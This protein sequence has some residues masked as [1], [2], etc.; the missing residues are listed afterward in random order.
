[1]PVLALIASPVSAQ[2]VINEIIQNPAAVGDS[3]GEWF[4]LFNPTG[5]A[6]DIEG[7][8]IS[9]NDID[10]HLINNGGPLLVPAGGYLVLGN[11]TDSGTNGGV[12]VAYSYGSNWFLANG[13]DEVVL[14]DGFMA[15]IDRVEYDG[16]PNFPDPTGASM[17]LESPASD[18]NVGSNWCTSTSSYGAGD[19]GTPGAANDA[20]VVP[21]TPPTVNSTSPANN[22]ID[23]AEGS[24]VV[25]TFSEEVTAPDGAF[26]IDC[27]I[28]SGHAFTASASP[29]T[30]FTLN[31][32]VDFDPVEKCTVT[33]D[34]DQVADTDGSPQNMTADFL[35]TF[36]TP[37]FVIDLEPMV[38]NEI[39]QN[40]SAVSDGNGEWF[41]LYNPGTET[42]DLDGWTVKDNGSNIFVVSGTLE[43]TAGA[44]VVFGT[45]GTFA[46]NGGVNVD[47]DYP[48]FSLGNGDDELILIDDND[49][50]VDRVE[51]DGGPTFPDPNGASMA[52]AGPAVDNNIGANWCTA[53]TPYGDGDLGTP[54]AANDCPLPLLVINE[55]IQN[56]GAV[57]DSNGEWFELYNPTGSAIDIEGWT[58]KDDGSN[59]QI[60]SNGGP[61]L[62]PAGG[63]LVLGNNSDSITNGGVTVDYQYSSFTLSNGGDEVVLIDTFANE[64]DRVNYD[65]GPAFPDPNGASM[66]LSIPGF[67]NNVGANW[68]TASTPFGDGDL[69]TPGAVNDCPALEI[70]E[71]QGS[72]AFSPFENLAVITRDNVVTGVTD[73]GFFIQTPANRD[74]NDSDTSNGIF[75]FTS[76]P[77]GVDEGDLVDIVGTVVEFFSFTQFDDDGL[78]IMIT[79]TGSLL[80]APILLDAVNPDPGPFDP[81]DMERFEGMLVKLENGI[82][83]GPTDGFGDTPVTVG[84]ARTFRE[85]GIEFPSMYIGIPEWDGNQEVIEVDPDGIAGMPDANIFAT[86]TVSA[87]GP[88]GFSF[89][90]YQI[91]ARTFG[92]GADPVVEI[93]VRERG[94][95]E[96][97]VGSFNIFRL[98]GGFKKL[99]AYVIDVLRSPDILAI[100]EVADISELEAL[101]DQIEFDD[102]TV[103]YT[104]SLIDG[105]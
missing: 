67:D 58:I 5:G 21:D 70:F 91:L 77:P 37:G 98:N 104:A 45:N 14:F 7:W 93:P 101:A 10:S 46:E 79:S 102:A 95:G 103:V 81:P 65:G 40:P 11:N 1:M 32:T 100:Q 56:P 99:S 49:N 90:D 6:V 29:A 48:S 66:S 3:A 23:I 44:Y 85:P 80:P 89:G 16:G 36:S 61:L 47:Y 15:E 52:L 22:A 28:S 20:C 78:A 84:P 96:F 71:I 50:E 76:M 60:I 72:S 105:N 17:S 18:N 31:P 39:I 86:Q 2:V 68:C 73:N 83:T 35:F 4:E 33:I 57:F 74:D 19:L 94:A 64:I 87:S 42:V 30:V 59:T 38:I 13:A 97:T 75:V 26:T 53:S 25:I 24:N 9:D 27:S 34:K 41:E 62:V 92:L 88:L 55:I 51:W 63:Y 43:V 54:G 8:T 69:G 82:A 12:T